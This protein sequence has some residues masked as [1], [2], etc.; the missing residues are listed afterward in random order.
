MADV[1]DGMK[2]EAMI[3]GG[4]FAVSELRLWLDHMM[5]WPKGLT[6]CYRFLISAFSRI[7]KGGPDWDCTVKSW[8]VTLAF[9]KV[10]PV[11]ETM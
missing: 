5:S 10:I 2:P 1:E 4:Y 8:A 3:A 11:S 7:R 9:A 6:P